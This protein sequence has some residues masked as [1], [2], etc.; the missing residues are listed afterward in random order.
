MLSHHNST[1]QQLVLPQNAQKHLV[2]QWIMIVKNKALV[3]A[4][5][6]IILN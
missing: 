1:A 2:Q 5:V 6:M 4:D 3:S